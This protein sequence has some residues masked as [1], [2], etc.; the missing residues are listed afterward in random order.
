MPSG[1]PA[2]GVL[3][4]IADTL[5]PGARVEQDG[6]LRATLAPVAQAAERR[7]PGTD[8][9]DWSRADREALVEELLAAPGS[10][11]AGALDAVLRV[12]ARSYYGDPASWPALGYRD[13]RPGTGWPPGP[14]AA[15]EPI[16]PGR[17]SDSYDAVV[18]GAGAGGGV[19]ACVLAEA[20]HRVLLV[21]RGES[22]RRVDLP[23]DHRRNARVWTGLERQ[24]DPPAAGNPRFVGDD[25]VLPTEQLWNNN[26]FTVGGGTRVY[27]AQAW[28]FCPED[29]RMGSTYGEPFVDWPIAYEDLEPYYDRVEWELG[30][31]GPEGLRPYDGVRSR[32]Y[33]MPPLPANAA[34]PALERGARALGLSTDAVPLLIN[35]VPY[36]G[37]PACIQCGTCVGFA[38]HADAKNGTDAT[39]IPRALAT[40]NCDLL[41]GAA[42]VRLVT[43]GPAVTGV[44][45][46]T[47]GG[48]R[49]V[50]AR[51]VVVCAGAIETARLLLVSEVGTE[52]GQVGRYL[53]GHAYAGA[54]GVFDEVV[55]DCVGPGPSIATTDLRHHNDGVLGG[56]I[57]V[58]EFVPIPIEAYLKLSAL[59]VV[60]AWGQA[61]AEGLRSAYPR[62]QFVVGPL[63]EVPS[64]ASRVTVEP[65]V[66]DRNGMPAVRLLA[67]APDPHDRRAAAFL[68]ERAEAWLRAGG[69]H[70]TR[71]LVWA[72]P[73]GPSAIQHQAGTCRMGTDP[74]TSVTDPW[75][76]VWGHDGVTVADGSLHVTNGGVNPVLTILALA[77]RVAERLGAEL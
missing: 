42:A 74:R 20:G 70:A 53:Q 12:A 75:G 55:Q 11:A 37:R 21:E 57:L 41:T 44:D 22:L 45:L 54:V 35:S 29:F 71:A 63:Q 60:P 50:R 43:D 34:Q 15:P 40:G 1:A 9:A 30:V 69:A 24:V 18:I 13:M 62:T 47:A 5:V 52:H 73:K 3:A 68:G 67:D 28:R 19:A 38:C 49:V 31:C 7:R 56:G 4:A 65:G 59:G 48:P 66:T 23:R 17:L 14:G 58:N 39:T 26:A 76:R 64:A 25:A 6:A 32:G 72:L 16:A 46:V 8:L 2:D 10:P 36:G 51:H 61:G 27:G 33:P 77:W